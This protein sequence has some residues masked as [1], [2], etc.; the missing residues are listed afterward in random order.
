M[1][2]NCYTFAYRKKKDATVCLYKDAEVCLRNLSLSALKY[3]GI[4]CNKEKNSRVAFH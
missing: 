1:L 3:H 2:S 4:V